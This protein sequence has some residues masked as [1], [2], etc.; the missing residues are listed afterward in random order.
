MRGVALC[1]AFER[2]AFGRADVAT[3][4]HPGRARSD[5]GISDHQPSYQALIV[6]AAFGLVLASCAPAVSVA[7]IA[8]TH[9]GGGPG[10]L[11][12]GPEIQTT[13]TCGTIAADS[14]IA[15]EIPLRAR[16][17]SY[18]AA[19]F[20]ADEIPLRRKGSSY[21]VP[22]AVNGL[23]PMPF[24]LDSGADTVS[25]PAEREARTGFIPCGLFASSA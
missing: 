16:G 10:H 12:G 11:S 23:P 18:L 8:A 17:S 4:D 19:P 13:I 20:A 24:V 3:G 25:L 15:E 9:C 14:A 7:D 6:A 5:G 2:A 22:V 1:L 21:L